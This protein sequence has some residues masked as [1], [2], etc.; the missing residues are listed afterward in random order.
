MLRYDDFINDGC[1]YCK[2]S[3]SAPEISDR[4]IEPFYAPYVTGKITKGDSL[5]F[6]PESNALDAIEYGDTYTTFDL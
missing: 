6:I 1:G 5:S 4:C 3:K 2:I